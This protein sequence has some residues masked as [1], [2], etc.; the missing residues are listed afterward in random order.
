M[1]FDLGYLPTLFAVL[2]VDFFYAILIIDLVLYL[3][4]GLWNWV[5]IIVCVA[6]VVIVLDNEVRKRWLRWYQSHEPY[7][8]DFDQC[9]REYVQLIKSKIK[10]P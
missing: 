8:I 5:V 7:T 1:E 6:P 9:L 10:N 2:L 3:S 4:F